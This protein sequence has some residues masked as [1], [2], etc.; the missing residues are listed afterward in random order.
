MSDN[1]NYDF[2]EFN[3]NNNVVTNQNLEFNKNRY[4][5]KLLKDNSE[6]VDDIYNVLESQKS[7]T[8]KSRTKVT[9]INID[10]SHRNI[11]PK[12]ILTKNINLD[13]NCLSLSND[14]NILKVNNTSS[15]HELNIG[16]RVILQNATSTFANLKGGLIFSNNT[17]K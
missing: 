3:K 2:N 13:N 5:L 10:S 7:I 14:S 1:L 9:R 15:K 17:N 6:Y 16:D 4:I 12:N 8:S 11:I